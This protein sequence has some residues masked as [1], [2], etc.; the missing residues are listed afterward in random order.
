[1]NLL[2]HDAVEKSKKYLK[3][4][5][6][7]FYAAYIDRNDLLEQT[8]INLQL[9]TNLVVGIEKVAPKF[10]HITFIQGGKAYG[11][12]LGTY[13][14]PA[15]ETDNRHFPPNFYYDQEDFLKT[16][17]IGKSWSWTAVRPDV[18]IGFALKNPMNIVNVIAIY[19]TI[20]KELQVPFRFPGNQKAYEA[21]VNVTD[22]AILAK[23]MEYTASQSNCHNQIFNITN[24]DVFRWKQLWPVF[25]SYFQVAYDEPQ[26]FSLSTY[27][28]DKEAVWKKITDTYALHDYT[29]HEL[30]NWSFGDFIFNVQN[31]AFFDV[32]KL[33]RHGFTA[34][35]KPSIESFIEAFN[36]LKVRNIIPL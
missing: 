7:I 3:N 1:M 23:G 19:A 36:L 33:R 34:M 2:E 29:L 31:D 13:K 32:N 21:L 16:H 10:K 28:K 18:I 17:S 14:T 9:L 12:H 11:A 25:A 27:M 4:V 6:H 5:T 35:H 8:E 24:G 22:V 26:T 20:C 15:L 30:V